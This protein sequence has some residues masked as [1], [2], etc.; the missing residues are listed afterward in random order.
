[1]GDRDF[2][3]QEQMLEKERDAASMYNLF[4]EIDTSNSGYIT[5]E[6]FE[7]HVNDARMAAYFHSMKLDVTEARVLFQ[8]FDYD[9]SGSIDI[10]EFILGC[11]KLK[12]EA[13]SMD[14]AILQ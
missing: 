11:D 3:V 12:G 5:M 8:L 6:E 9:Q 2:I 7:A 10:E 1:M 13:K 14:M 4:H